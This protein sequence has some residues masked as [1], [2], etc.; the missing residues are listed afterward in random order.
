MRQQETIVAAV[1]RQ[2]TEELL[3]H[4]STRL[5]QR[6]LVVRQALEQLVVLVLRTLQQRV[7]RPN[8]EEAIWTLAE[9]A[10]QQGALQYL[11]TPE[12]YAGRGEKLLE[13]LLGTSYALTLQRLGTSTGLS[14]PACLPLLEVAVAAVLGTIGEAAARAEL[15]VQVLGHW[16]QQQPSAMRPAESAAAPP[17]PTAAPVASSARTAASPARPLPP[18]VA[19]PRPNAPEGPE[20]DSLHRFT[21]AGAGTWEKIGGG[22]T[23]TPA[24]RSAGKRWLRLPS[25]PQWKG[26]FL[27]PVL[28]LV[29][30]VGYG[31]AYC[32]LPPTQAPGTAGVHELAPINFTSATTGTEPRAITLAE[33]KQPAALGLSDAPDTVLPPVPA[34][35]YD[36]ASDTY[37]YTT[38]QPLVL[39]LPDGSRQRV[40]TNSTEYRLYSML[41]DPAWQVDSLQP[42]TALL[43]VDRVSFLSGQAT[44]T[45]ESQEQLQNLAG[46]L[47]AFPRAVIKL[48]GY[49]DNSGD[50][51]RNQVLSLARARAARQ[52]LVALGVAG[53]RLVAQ[54]YGAQA[55]IASNEA[56]VGR[57][58]NR[59]LTLQVL[60]KDGPLIQSALGALPPESKLL[61]KQGPART[62]LQGHRSRKAVVRS[63][64]TRPRSKVGKWLQHLSRR[65]RGKR[66]VPNS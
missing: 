62:A 20:K 2:L 47:K 30:L 65:V 56:P 26:S 45:A 19:P 57:A 6:A 36:A 66:P 50:A 4:L 14:A 48:G 29:F 40:G 13:R 61:Q 42:M 53:G 9:N 33:R 3:Q 31:G 23:F 54:G 1:D 12:A 43:P 58:L 41:A 38:G 37:I 34:G 32:V 60:R 5:S 59:R 24:L 7:A 21:V 16:L 44:L 64:A 27:V 35:R 39:T 8:G 11:A 15:N 55:F 25:L 63:T 28:G 46:L 18:P 17:R 10:R 51:D 22:I 52:A 49:T